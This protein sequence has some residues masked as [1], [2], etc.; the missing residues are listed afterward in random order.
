MVN[1][2]EGGGLG[3]A[4]Q[5][6][7]RRRVTDINDYSA[8][9]TNDDNESLVRPQKMVT[10]LKQGNG[11]TLRNIDKQIKLKFTLLLILP[12]V[13]FNGPVFN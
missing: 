1:G 6:H 7:H 2:L 9:E 5:P 4:R 12:N 13:F 3:A 10:R 11:L 8:L